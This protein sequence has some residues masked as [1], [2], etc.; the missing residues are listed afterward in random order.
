MSLNARTNPRP[1]TPL[2]RITAGVGLALATV[3]A[4]TFCDGVAAAAPAPVLVDDPAPAP[5]ADPTSAINA[6]NT[7]F[8]VLN[9]LL[10]SVLPGS[11]S[12]I[13]ET[14]PGS[15]LSPAGSYPSSLSPTGGYPSSLLPGQTPALPGQ[16]SPL[17]PAQ[18]PGLPGQ[19]SPLSPAQTPAVPGQSSSLAPV[20]T[21]PVV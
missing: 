6:A 12:L 17:A 4:I 19:T 2:T 7:I 20:Q 13:P 18:V 21:T 16:T 9:S 14:T 15:P 8:G 11:G 5:V 10:N 1:R 3:G